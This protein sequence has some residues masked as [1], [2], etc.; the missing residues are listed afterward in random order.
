MDVNHKNYNIALY[1]KTYIK[2]YKK[3]IYKLY[4]NV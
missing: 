4:K 2:L 1:I 3:G